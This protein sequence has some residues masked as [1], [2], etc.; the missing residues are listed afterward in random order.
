MRVVLMREFVSQ[1]HEVECLVLQEGGELDS[2]ARDVVYVHAL[3]A[4]RQRNAAAAMVKY[5]RW[6]R[7]DAVLG[8]VWPLSCLVS[9]S[10]RLAVPKARVLVSEHNELS[11]LTL[12]STARRAAKI[13][14]SRVAYGR[15]N[16]VVAVSKA[17]AHRL[18]STHAA[19]GPVHVVNNPAYVSA[20]PRARRERG[21]PLR[22]LSVGTLK[23][24]KRHD[25]LLRAFA[26]A[27]PQGPSTLTILGD[28]E[29]RESLV[30]Q[31]AAL[32]LA[33]RV[34]FP[35]FAKDTSSFYQGADVYVHTAD[36]EGFGNVLV[37]ALSHGLRVIS[38]SFP[39][40]SEILRSDDEGVVV[41]LGDD[42]ALVNALRQ[43]N[44][45]R[46]RSEA[47]RRRAMDFH[48]T[49]IANKYLDL[50]FA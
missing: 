36:S 50:L 2:V 15:A 1:G 19:A 44:C 30:R 49:R 38:T 3:G 45:S 39:A 20:T 22:F 25:R 24:V 46:E 16:A 10:A 35:G 41:P 43:A 26:A 8:S 29:L 5:F 4:R 31:A 13:G 11:D 18:R 42:A 17:V 23:K 9:L 7:P 21:E 34:H 28:G 37:E 12:G 6:R 14:F 47:A 48:P 27:Y 40:A 33:E 32:G